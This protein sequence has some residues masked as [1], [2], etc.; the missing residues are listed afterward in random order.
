MS[1]PRRCGVWGSPVAHSLSPTLHRAAYA[2][3]ELDWSYGARETTAEELPA[4]VAGLDASWRG[5]SL[6]MPLKEAGLALCTRASD[7]A[8]AVGAVN[9]LIV[10]GAEGPVGDNTDVSGFASA[11]R[12]AGIDAVGQAIVVGAGATARSAV[13]AL[14]AEGCRD[15]VVVAREPARAGAIVA[16]AE[17]LGVPVTVARIADTDRPGRAAGLLVS[18]IPATAQTG[19]TRAALGD[20]VAQADAVC[21]VGYGPRDTPLVTAARQAG[22]RCAT[23]FGLL[24]HQAAR[25][26]ELMTGAAVAPLEQMRAAGLAELARREHDG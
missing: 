8:R 6:T 20:L 18:T 1:G 13:A 7:V 15:L 14:A 3:L 23:G 10:D 22:L 21:D 16:L 12:E 24:L 17:R 9:T 5:L 26:I 25:Q 4:L 2:A 19:V 11:W